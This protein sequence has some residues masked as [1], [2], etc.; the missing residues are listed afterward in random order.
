MSS[1]LNSDASINIKDNSPKSNILASSTCTADLIHKVF[2]A[3]EKDNNRTKS[4]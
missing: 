3:Y 1:V 4:D 2:R